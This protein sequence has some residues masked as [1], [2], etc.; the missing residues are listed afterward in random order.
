MSLG[1]GSALDAGSGSVRMRCS[2]TCGRPATA[3]VISHTSPLEQ[4]AESFAPGNPRANTT[5]P[6]CRRRRFGDCAQESPDAGRVLSS[7]RPTDLPRSEWRQSRWL[8]RDWNAGA[9]SRVPTAA[10]DVHLAPISGLRARNGR[11][12]VEPCVRLAVVLRSGGAVGE[13]AA[14]AASR[15][16]ALCG[17]VMRNTG[18]STAIPANSLK[19]VR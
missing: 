10:S 8:Y 9:C 4:A 15:P 14:H 19:D 3:R 17:R 13:V 18:Y 7:A 16:S 2:P 6:G 12:T 11:G 1:P 5:G